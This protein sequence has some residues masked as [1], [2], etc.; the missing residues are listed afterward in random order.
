MGTMP[1]LILATAGIIGV[2]ALW[3]VNLIFPFFHSLTEVEIFFR[4]F[5][6][7]VILFFSSGFAKQIFL[8][9]NS[10]NFYWQNKSFYKVG[11]AMGVDPE[12]K[13][14][15]LVSF[16]AISLSLGICFPLLFS[17]LIIVEAMFNIHGYGFK[18]WEAAKNLDFDALAYWVPGF[19]GAFL[20]LQQL[21]SFFSKWLGKCLASY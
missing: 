18:M 15:K 5:I 17:E 11:L 14:R 4:M 3:S 8:N 2:Y 9:I 7:T 16:R 10:E 1:A 13:M 12:Y 20:V 6:P 19:L 21:N